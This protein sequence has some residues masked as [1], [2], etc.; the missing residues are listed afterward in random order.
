MPS[1]AAER[2]TF[3]L[4]KEGQ[5]YAD[6]E[7]LKV[8]QRGVIVALRNGSAQAHLDPDEARE[9]ADG[10]TDHFEGEQEVERFAETLRKYAD[11]LEN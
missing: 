11:Q 4:R 3:K 2:E 6:W 10:A 7:L 5:G 1:E 9:V 8:P